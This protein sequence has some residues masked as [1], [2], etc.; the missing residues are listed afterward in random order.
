M[1]GLDQQHLESDMEDPCFVGGLSKKAWR[2]VS[3]KW[4][5]LLVSVRA[6]D[7]REFAFRLECSNYP[8]SAPC[9]ELWDMENNCLLA[10]SKWPRSGYAFRPD[11]KAFVAN[12]IYMGCDR[13]GLQYGVSQGWPNKTPN[14]VWTPGRKINFYLEQVY[15]KLNRQSYS[16]PQNT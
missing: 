13:L 14:Q 8:Q 12:G 3:L 1:I 15:E 9:G 11:V 10:E 6:R 5:Y 16:P 2:V 7:D 4:P